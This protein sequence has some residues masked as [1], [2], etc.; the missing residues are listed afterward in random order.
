MVEM[1]EMDST[2]G[3]VDLVVALEAT[4]ALAAAAV[5]LAAVILAALLAEAVI[6][7]AEAQQEVGKFNK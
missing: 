3:K 4:V 5:I 2:V 7:V 1:V 6:L